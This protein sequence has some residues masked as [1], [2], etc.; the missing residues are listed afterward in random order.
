MNLRGLLEDK[1]S[2]S[3]PITINLA[4]PAPAAPPALRPTNERA[5]E[6]IV[7]SLVDRSRQA[8]AAVKALAPSPARSGG[9][10]TVVDVA[11]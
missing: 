3:V 1:M 4:Q 8:E 7:R 9:T 6:D 5:R 11:V 2:V 10:G